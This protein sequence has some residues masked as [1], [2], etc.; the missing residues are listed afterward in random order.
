MSVSRCERPT[1]YAS[2][3]DILDRLALD[4][5]STD[6]VGAAA[7]AL[8]TAETTAITT[9]E[10]PASGTRIVQAA[11][12]HWQIPLIVIMLAL[13]FLTLRG[14][15]PSTHS[16]ARAISSASVGWIIVAAVLEWVSLSMFA[17][18]Q[19]SLLGALDVSMTFPRALAVTYARSA[20]S[21]SM[22]AGSA[23]S[24]GFAFQQ[25]RKSG[26]TNDKAAA[27]MVLSGVVSFIGLGTLYVAGI[28]GLIASGPQAAFRA[29]PTLIYAIGA[30]AVFIVAA[31]IL[32]R[33]ASFT[34]PA[35]RTEI[36]A[37]AGRGDRLRASLVRTVEAGRSL[38][39]RDW[40]V[41]G[42]FA[43]ANWLLDL[44]CL[45][46]TARAFSLPVG[47]FAISTMYLGVQIIR[48]L[49]ITPGGIGLIETG[50]LAGLTHAGAGAGAATAAVLTYRVFS[51]WLII[52][53]GGLAWLGLR[54]R[55][56]PANTLTTS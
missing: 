35:P 53:L 52:P 37:P 46:A 23:I 26:A 8:A 41:A 3:D 34:R 22:P 16:I 56:N 30:L 9:I 28:F 32:R 38:R 40:G 13:A 55:P 43:I 4:G 54:A 33:R 36:S 12:K 25:Y 42:G 48:Q 17:R 6:P 45:A 47:L 39:G 50:L 31:W 19:R 20:I 10:A 5:L 11:R 1:A 15:L 24:A 29:H 51:C 44:L 21:I 18:Q 27:V 2:H 49:P 7:S 14:R